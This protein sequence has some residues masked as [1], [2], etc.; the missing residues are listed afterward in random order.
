MLK[1]EILSFSLMKHLRYWYIKHSQA[2]DNIFFV[3]LKGGSIYINFGNK[4]FIL[5]NSIFYLNKASLVTKMLIYIINIVEKH[6]KYFFRQEVRYI[7]TVLIK[8]FISKMQLSWKFFQMYIKEKK[9]NY[10]KFSINIIKIKKYY[11][12]PEPAVFL[13]IIQI[14]L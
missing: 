6:I 9:N 8:T 5:I 14:F 10:Y 13:Q 11:F 3:L 4:G 12:R 2:A 7:V 1:Y